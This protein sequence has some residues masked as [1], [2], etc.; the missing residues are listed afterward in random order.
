[1]IR[2]QM[3]GEQ[4]FQEMLRYLEQFPKKLD[5]ALS[6]GMQRTIGAAYAFILPRI[7]VRPGSGKARAALEKE[8]LGYGKT[9]TG[10]VGFPGGKGAPHYINIVEYGARPHSLKAKSKSR[11]TAQRARYEKR[12]EK[13]TLTGQHFMVNGQ[14][15]TKA[16]HPGFSKRGFMAAG[17]S[18]AKPIFEKEMQIAVENTFNE[19]PK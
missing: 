11:T 16:N 10:V 2:Y 1:M 9:I 5:R 6:P 17:F 14:W 15:V 18:A 13:G 8:I 12:L 4:K 3:Q 7:P 19:A